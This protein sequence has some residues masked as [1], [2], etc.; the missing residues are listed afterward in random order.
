MPREMDDPHDDSSR[1]EQ[2]PID[3][4]GSNTDDLPNDNE[5]YD[6]AMEVWD[7]DNDESAEKSVN[8]SS[9]SPGQS[10]VIKSADAPPIDRQPSS[11]AS[12]SSRPT[13][14]IKPTR[15]PDSPVRAG[16][17]PAAL[18]PEN[19][20]PTS[21]I[22]L[23]NNLRTNPPPPPPKRPVTPAT[24]TANS[25]PTKHSPIGSLPTIGLSIPNGSE[26]KPYEARVRPSLPQNWGSSFS[27]KL[28]NFRFPGIEKRGIEACVEEQEIVLTGTPIVNGQ[29]SIDYQYTLPREPVQGRPEL[30]Q[31]GRVAWFVNPDPR[32]LWK[33]L[34]PDA[35]LP[36]QKSHTDRTRVVG[37][38]TL[39][40]ASVR[41]RSHAHEGTFRD[42]DFCVRYD[43]ASG[44]YLLTVCDGAG[45]AKFSRRG[46]QIA[47]QTVRDSIAPHFS[48]SLASK[49]FENAAHQFYSNAES[50]Q[51]QTIRLK[52][53][54]AMGGS[55]MKAYNAIQAEAKQVGNAELNH[56]A[57]TIIFTIAKHYPWG[58]FVGAFCIG[59]GGAAIYSEKSKVKVLNQPDGGEFAGQTR[60]LTMPDILAS[61]EQVMGRIQFGVSD[62]LTA[63]VAMTDG[64][65]DAKFETDNRFF[66]TQ[67]W[68]EFWRDLER[69]VTLT[70]DNPAADEQLLKWLDFWSPGNHDDRTIALLIP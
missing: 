18:P 5:C 60:F 65:S 3:K 21:T 1:N 33:N 23:P 41:G 59:D 7:I 22:N 45:S 24:P 70:K 57:T 55:A 52:L 35:S 13:T 51:R 47:C 28:L 64:V 4:G 39:I 16:D 49:E 29:V 44:W 32:S 53:C 58:W 36:Y 17:P 42:D 31:T 19:P 34:S 48:G 43:E 25:P 15:K 63:L 8:P 61:N 40:A 10:R 56:F 46:S 69:E 30:E 68:H 9:R 11:T 38:A 50:D 62:D 26:G 12:A 2:P 6:R 67:C 54:D 37:P 27:L 66:D 20:L 14:P